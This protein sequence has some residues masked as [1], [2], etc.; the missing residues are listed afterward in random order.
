MLLLHKN[1]IIAILALTH[2]LNLIQ[3]L[4]LLLIV[5]QTQNLIQTLTIIYKRVN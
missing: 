1:K 2:T 5:T 4:T 3:T